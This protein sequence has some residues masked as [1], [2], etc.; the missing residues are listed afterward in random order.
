MNN[1]TRILFVEDV[2]SDAELAMFELKKG[3]LIFEHIRVDTRHEFIK[4]LNDFN[5]CT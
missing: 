3:E 4:A 5:N 1:C 2:L